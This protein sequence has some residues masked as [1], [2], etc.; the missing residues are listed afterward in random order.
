MLATGFLNDS[1]PLAFLGY[2]FG[3]CFAYDCSK[4]LKAALN[5]SV[6]QV[7]S[8]SGLT[9][10]AHLEFKRFDDGTFESLKATVLQ[11]LRENFGRAPTGF[12]QFLEN[13]S[14]EEVD[15]I[16]RVFHR[17]FHYSHSWVT[18][19]TSDTSLLESD[20]LWIIGS[21]DPTTR[22]DGWKVFIY[23]FS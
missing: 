22:D 2:S 23:I 14:S 12:M 4:Y 10:D 15:E 9:L 20:F 5:Y 17:G 11:L 13:H 19:M 3:T 1:I 6:I 8:I 16:L 7:I 18:N 21:D